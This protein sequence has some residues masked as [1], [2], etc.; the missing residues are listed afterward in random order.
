MTIVTKTARKRPFLDTKSAVAWARQLEMQQ[1]ST[2]VMR[3]CSLVVLSYLDA[4]LE[5]WF[6]RKDVWSSCCLLLLT[7]AATVVAKMCCLPLDPERW[8]KTSTG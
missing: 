4:G 8:C 2:V 3:L 7:L 5:P 1:K 6:G